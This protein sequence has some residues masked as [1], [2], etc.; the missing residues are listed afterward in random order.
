MIISC[1]RIIFFVSFLAV[2]CSAVSYGQEPSVR[3]RILH[4]LDRVVLVPQT[5]WCAQTE[6]HLPTKK[7]I[8]AEVVRDQVLLTI[9]DSEIL[10]DTLILLEGYLDD[11]VI[12]I[13]GV[14]YGIGWW[15]ESKEDRYYEGRL[16]IRVTQDRKLSVILELPLE[17]YLCGVVPYEIGTDSPLEALKAQA[18]AARSETIVALNKGMYHGDHYDIC[19]DVEC[20]V[21]GGIAKRT[22]AIMQAVEETHGLILSDHGTPINAYYASNCGGFSEDIENI[23]PQRSGPKP[24]WSGHPDC[25]NDIYQNLS[26]EQRLRAWLSG[27]PNVN[28]NPKHTPGLSEWNRKYFRW[29]IQTSID[30]LSMWIAKKKDIG[31]VLKIDSL[32]RGVSGR[33][34]KAV[35]I[36]TRGSYRVN[37][38]LEFRQIWNPPLRSSCIILDPEGAPGSPTA[39]LISGAGWGHGVG[40][41]QSGAIA[42]AL[43]RKGFREILNHYYRGAEILQ[44]YE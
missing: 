7:S 42:L 2:L 15:W 33:I 43:V 28:C 30:T 34:L 20:Q 4:S 35:F 13:E 9:N 39:F 16:E 6:I 18:V 1:H 19:S 44:I 38:Q 31:R 3:V 21:Y 27:D 23:W 17:Q 5:D 12:K 11:S 32:E 36:G 40:M 14:P 26:T 8:K 37:D 24:Y 10:Q 25:D 29:K 22:S 41:C